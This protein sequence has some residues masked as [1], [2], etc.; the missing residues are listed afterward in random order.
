MELSSGERD[1]RS[2]RDVINA[3]RKQI[4]NGILGSGNLGTGTLDIRHFS[5]QQSEHP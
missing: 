3:A 2:K 1:E 4:G 5:I